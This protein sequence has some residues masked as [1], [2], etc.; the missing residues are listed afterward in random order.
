MLALLLMLSVP[1]ELQRP[2][3]ELTARNLEAS[4][5]AVLLTRDRQERFDRFALLMNWLLYACP[6]AREQLGPVAVRQVARFLDVPG[7]RGNATIML[8]AME[9]HL[10]AVRAQIRAALADQRRQN[11]RQRRNNIVFF[12]PGRIIE[13]NL[14]CLMKII[15][16]G[17]HRHRMCRYLVSENEARSLPDR[18]PDEPPG[19]Q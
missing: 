13:F 12:G 6:E 16:S 8:F 7:L 14:R 19:Y 3:T 9:P 10:R 11:E 5:T 15:E 17:H 18:D 4:T 1:Q 2:C